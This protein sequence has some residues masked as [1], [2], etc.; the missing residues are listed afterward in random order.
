MGDSRPSS[1]FSFSLSGGFCLGVFVRVA[2]LLLIAGVLGVVLQKTRHDALPW[3]GD[4]AHYIETQAREQNLRLADRE[5]VLE[6]IRTGSHLLIDARSLADYQ[7][8]HIESALSLPAEE[9]ENQLETLSILTPGDA[10]L[11]YCSGR[12]CDESLLT[13]RL[14]RERG[15]TNLTVYPGGWTEWSGR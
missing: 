2:V 10:L 14:L 9:P 7:A 4:W 5:A 8:G 6:M 12:E 3:V 13:A 15:M 1:P 11:I